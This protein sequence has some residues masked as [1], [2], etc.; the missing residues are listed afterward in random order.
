MRT[1]IE[2][3]L[4]AAL[5]PLATL[6]C[7]TQ[8]G[9]ARAQEAATAMNLDSR[10][11]RMELASEKVAPRAR[12]Q[13]MAHRAGWHGKVRIVDTEL[14]GLKMDKDD[15]ATLFVKVAWQ[16]ADEG[17]LRLTR[18]KQKWKDFRGSWQLVGEERLDGD[19]GLIGEV[20]ERP[21]ESGERKKAAQFPTIRI[22]ATPPE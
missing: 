2:V 18:L 4:L 21:A 17:D 11:G 10:F 19:V 12:D 13:W 6:G 16:R 1:R 22:G 3:M 20:V 8:T 14:A 7:P 9:P 5:L 15:E